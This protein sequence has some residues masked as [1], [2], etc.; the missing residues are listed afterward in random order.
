M[1]HDD[2][3]EQEMEQLTDRVQM[4]SREKERLEETYMALEEKRKTTENRTRHTSYI[5]RRQAE[6]K[7]AEFLHRYGFD[8]LPSPGIV[9]PNASE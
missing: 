1:Q 2:G 9:P 7:L 5:N 3:K 4:Y 8:G 6:S